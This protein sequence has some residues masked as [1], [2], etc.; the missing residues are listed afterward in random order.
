MQ[1]RILAEKIVDWPL[2]V[3]LLKYVKITY[4]FFLSQL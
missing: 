4:T 1:R 2:V 3:I